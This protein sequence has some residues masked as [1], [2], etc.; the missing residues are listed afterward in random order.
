MTTYRIL[1]FKNSVDLAEHSAELISNEIKK[2]LSVKERVSICLSGGS[3]PSQ[4][5]KL[6]S[7]IDLKW[8]R[9]DVF[10]GDDRCVDKDSDLSNSLMIRK[11]LLSKSP[12]SEANFLPIPINETQSPVQIASDFSNLLCSYF[13]S[14]KVSFDI[15]LLGLG[16][17]G[18][19]ASLFPGTKSLNEKEKLATVSNG[20]GLDRITLTCSVLSAAKKIIFLVSGTSKQ[21]ALKRLIDK[22]EDGERTPA[23]LI[24]PN[25]EVLILA[26]ADASAL[27]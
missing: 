16:D 9:V 4:T 13:H 11:T 3:T 15:V 8:K 20:K 23:K 2:V 27:I 12:G 21:I 14:Q 6:L 18:H 19:T 22:N 17:D 5:Y 1:K 10:L 26:D 24:K 25:S 7:Q